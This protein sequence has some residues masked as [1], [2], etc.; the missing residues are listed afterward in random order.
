M[1]ERKRASSAYSAARLRQA[2]AVK[3][4]GATAQPNAPSSPS[5]AVQSRAS[6]AASRPSPALGVERRPSVDR[7]RGRAVGVRGAPSRGLPGDELALALDAPAVAGNRRHPPAR[8]DGRESPPRAGWR[9]RPERPRAPPSAGRP[10]ARSPRRSP[11]GRREL[12][13]A[14]ARPAAGKRS[15]GCRAAG[16]PLAG[17]LDEA[18]DPRDRALELAVAAHELRAREAVLEVAHQLIGIVPQ[19]DGANALIRGGHQHR[20][21]RGLADR[22]ADHRARAAA[23]DRGRGHARAG[24]PRSHRSGSKS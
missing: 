24:P 15:R 23:P 8:R 18:D 1:R 17:R 6:I 3:S 21:E 7:L 16:P 19:H 2:S 11:S 20:P 10:P 22:E 12:R 5:S 14:P 9:R 4:F 13:A